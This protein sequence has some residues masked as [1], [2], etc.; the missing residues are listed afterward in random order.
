MPI[1]LWDEFS[2]R[3][4]DLETAEIAPEMISPFSALPGLRGFWP[5]SGV[6][7]GGNAIDQSKSGRTL[8]QNGAPLYNYAGLAPY[9]EFN[10]I[11]EW[12]SRPDEAGLDILGTEVYVAPTARGLTLGGWFWVDADT[13]A[14]QMFLS[15]LSGA[16]VN[17]SYYILLV[18]PTRQVELGIEATGGGGITWLPS[19]ATVTYQTWVFLAGRFDTPNLTVWVNDVAVSIGGG[20]AGINNSLDDFCIGAYQGGNFPLDG[21]ASLCFLCA[22]AHSD[23]VISS[24]YHQTRSVF[25]V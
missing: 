8:T 2:E 20:P 22:A 23:S 3:L 17:R 19:T 7:A 5:M 24:L 13:G 10:G 11:N 6:D 1:E 9:I 12:L 14:D 21:R 16:G 25:G 15:K 18:R 4:R